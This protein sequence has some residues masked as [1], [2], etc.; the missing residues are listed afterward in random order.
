[1]LIAQQICSTPNML[2]GLESSYTSLTKMNSALEAFPLLKAAITEVVCGLQTVICV[3][4]QMT[5]VHN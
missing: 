4:H 1:M 5:F 3:I 2:L